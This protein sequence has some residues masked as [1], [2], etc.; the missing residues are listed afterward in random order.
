MIFF[1]LKM[2]VFLLRYKNKN[3]QE[4]ELRKKDC[5]EQT[6]VVM[7]QATLDLGGKDNNHY[8][9]EVV[10]KGCRQCM[11]VVQYVGDQ[12]EMKIAGKLQRMTGKVVLIKY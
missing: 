9:G 1:A 10:G 7:T 8:S 12:F 6:S 4:T 3:I 5:T 11:G 2:C